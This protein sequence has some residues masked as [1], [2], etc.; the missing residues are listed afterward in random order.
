VARAALATS[1]GLVSPEDVAR[2]EAAP[3]NDALAQQALA[4]LARREGNLGRADALYQGLLTRHPDDVVLL[5]NAANVRLHLGHMESAFELYERAI[6]VEPSALL[7]FNLSQAYGRAFQV[8]NLTRALSLA[9]AENGDLVAELT[10]LQGS[11]PESF[12]VDLPLSTRELLA[13]VLGASDGRLWAAEFRAPFAPGWMG[14]SLLAGAAPFGLALLLGVAVAGRLEASGWC[15]RCR[16][17]VCPRCD[18][19]DEGQVRGDICGPC[20]KLFNQP[21]LT[22][23]ELR[24]ARI[25]ALRE[26]GARIDKLAAGVSIAIPGVAGVVGRRPLL[27][28]WSAVCFCIALAAL[29]GREGA[30]P[31]PLVAGGAG[32]LAFF[33]VAAVA[34]LG[35]ALCVGISLAA[36]RHA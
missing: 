36:R 19:G 1:R 33:C 28:F 5:T 16:S 3:S 26:R 9:Q 17:R 13:R 23:R 2:L 6:D 8:D 14:S 32:P 11:Q 24:V 27:G 30:V 29:L 18:E 21:E 31:D 25:E 4:R 35:Y 10:R 34:G 22:D 12:V 7:L 20:N 15:V